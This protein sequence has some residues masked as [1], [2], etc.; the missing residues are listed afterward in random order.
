MR[1]DAW[2]DDGRG[3]LPFGRP[4]R[5]LLFLYG[6]RVVPFEIRRTDSAQ[7]PQV[8]DVRSAAVTYGHRFLT[9]SGRAGRAIKVRSFDDY[10]A[11]LLENFVVLS[12]EERH[13]RIMRDLEA[14]ARKL[15]GRVGTSLIGRSALLE[16]VPDLIEYPTVMAGFVQ[17]DFLQLPAEVLTTTLVHHQH[18]FPVVDDEGRLKNAFLAVTNTDSA[19]EKIVARNAERVVTARLRDAS[20]FW[21]ADRR[22][23]LEARRARLETILFHKKLGTYLDKSRRVADLAGWIAGDVLGRSDQAAEAREAASLCK[24]DLATDMVREFTELQGAMGG[25]YAREEGRSPAVWKAIYYQYLPIAVEADAPPAREDLEGA[26]VTWAAVSLAD[27]LDTLVGLFAAGEKPT[28]SRD[29]YGMRRSAQGIVR[30]L[31]DL[32][33]LTGLEAKPT[34]G[35][36]MRKAREGH[37]AVPVVPEVETRRGEFVRERLEFL[38]RQRGYAGEVVQTVMWGTSDDINPHDLLQRAEAVK[39]ALQTAEFLE[40]ARLYKRASNLVL[41]HLGADGARG[42]E[43]E[44]RALLQDRAEIALS[45]ALQEVAPQVRDL[46]ARGDYLRLIRTL[47]TLAPQVDTLFNEVLVV[48]DD[49]DVRNARLVLLGELRELVL[50]VGDIAHCAPSLAAG[51]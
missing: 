44:G 7:S 28:G 10:R 32:Q 9:T 16:E 45:E 42:R 51:R 43:G 22:L 37:A 50:A 20:F 24:A 13:D 1:W 38:L 49:L 11:R 30:I 33:V 19:N 23:G 14:K 3:E 6:G 21:E 4:I 26:S 31:A 17:E 2:L 12:R 48:T 27:K 36:L 40:L 5:W 34:L 25:I 39:R 29:P 18:Y 15:N 35:A 47:A 41:E 8:Q 46:A